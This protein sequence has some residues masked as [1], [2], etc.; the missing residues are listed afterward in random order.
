MIGQTFLMLKKGSPV[1]TPDLV[2]EAQSKHKKAMSAAEKGR[3]A[4]PQLSQDLRTQITDD[5]LY[6]EIDSVINEV[7]PRRMARK[8]ERECKDPSM[9]LAPFPSLSAH[10]S[11]GRDVGGATDVICQL[12]DDSRR[13]CTTD[14]GVFRDLIDSRIDELVRLEAA[15]SEGP[16]AFAAAGPFRHIPQEEGGIERELKRL[17]SIQSE[18]KGN[19]VGLSRREK[20][21]DKMTAAEDSSD[22]FFDEIAAVLEKGD[23]SV[24]PVYLREP[25]KVRTITKG[26]EVAYW[27]LRDVQRFLWRVISSHPTFLLI[28]TPITRDILNERLMGWAFRPGAW[29]SGDYSAATDNLRKNLTVHAWR[30]VCER[31]H[32]PSWVRRI[33]EKALVEHVV[34]YKDEVIVQ[35]N[36]QLMGS[37]LSFPILCIINAAICRV[38]FDYDVSQPTSGLWADYEGELFAKK[39]L[40]LRDLPI[41]V[42]GDDCVMRYTEQ[43]KELWALTADKAGMAPSPGKCYYS[44][45]FLQM[46][47][48]LFLQ[49]KDGFSRIPFLNFS[50]ASLVKA[51]GG[52]QRGLDSLGSISREF[53]R[54]FSGKMRQ[55]A[56]SI[57]IRRMAPVLKRRIPKGM[58]W[59][60]P[61]WFGGV[62]IPLDVSTVAE[63]LTPYQSLIASYCYNVLREGGRA[64]SILPSEESSAVGWVQEALRK[65]EL[66]VEQRLSEEELVPMPGFVPDASSNYTPFLWAAASNGRRFQLKRPQ[67]QS[68]VRNFQRLSK[69]AKQA[70]KDGLALVPL[71]ELLK[72]KRLKSSVP[73]W[74]TTKL[75]QLVE[76]PRNVLAELLARTGEGVGTSL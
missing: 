44:D 70:Q 33:G 55:R 37:V 40:A 2:A 48:D 9:R 46:N 24:S 1:V 54:D 27:V 38:P 21:K 45:R 41:L 7:F 36:G 17:R 18:F 8:I 16:E 47:S 32:F 71:A 35:Q 68:P 5:V 73:E 50:L 30:S 43:Q 62:G 58:P 76:G 72:Y 4:P 29:L 66:F 56:L 3:H 60:I 14:D 51:K 64:P 52:D 63:T 49:G 28:G 11:S 31:A 42:N 53:C 23:F 25:L 20:G 6:R 19:T 65:A 75:D 59:G 10:F 34:H 57:W 74:V 26:P 39:R 69:S 15:I 61:E 67:Q 13:D 22:R 12:W